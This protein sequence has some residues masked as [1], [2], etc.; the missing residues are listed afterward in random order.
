[1]LEEEQP[2]RR[3]VELEVKDPMVGS[4][5][6]NGGAGIA[7]KGQPGNCNAPPI[8]AW[9]RSDLQASLPNTS[10]TK[11]SNL[12]DSINISPATLNSYIQ[13]SHPYDHDLP[14]VA[15]RR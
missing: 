15:S 10:P 14:L 5:G 12:Q 8:D 2:R 13:Y 9:T 11:H 7:H 1:M 6:S 4:R 3:R